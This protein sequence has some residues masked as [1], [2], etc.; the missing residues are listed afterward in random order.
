MKLKHI[1]TCL[2]TV[3]LVLFLS[4]GVA[5]AAGK[6][7]PNPWKECGIG[8]MIF[9]DDPTIAAI[10]N[11]IWDLGTTAVSSAVTTPGACEGSTVVAAR[12]IQDTYATVE[13]ETVKGQ[14]EHLTAVLN[15]MGCEENAHGEIISAV[16]DDL[17]TSMQSDDYDSMD[18]TAKAESYFLAMQEQTI[19]EFSSQ[20]EG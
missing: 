4:L 8:A 20:C 5:S 18:V 19:G 15:L 12:M 9:N 1:L 16:R 10:S 6:K 11:I 2:V 14:G 3:S 17:L 13:N 7:R